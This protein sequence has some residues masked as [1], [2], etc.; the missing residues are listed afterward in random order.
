[1]MK[2]LSLQTKARPSKQVKKKTADGLK[3]KEPESDGDPQRNPSGPFTF[4][5]FEVLGELA[6]ERIAIWSRINRKIYRVAIKG[7]SLDKLDR[8]GGAEV[9]G[10][11]CRRDD[12][13]K[14]PFRFLKRQIIV[15]AGKTQLGDPDYL[16]QGIHLLSNSRLLIVNGGEARIWNGNEFAAQ[17]SPLINKKFIDFKPGASWIDMDRVVSFVEELDEAL[18]RQ[19]VVDEFLEAVS[20]WGFK[21]QLDHI[22]VAGWFLSQVVQTIWA[23]KPH[24][25]VSG[26]HGSG[27]SLLAEFF[28]KIGG[29]LA[30]KYEGQGS[31][32]AG[33]RQDLIKNDSILISIDEFEQSPQRLQILDLCRSASRGGT[34]SKGSSTHVSIKFFIYHMLLL[35]SIEIGLYRAAEN[36]RF[37]IVETRK[38]NRL[39]PQIPE[40]EILEKLRVKIFAYSIWA[41][42]KA[43][44]LVSQVK[45]IPGVDRR[46]LESMA[47]PI[48]MIAVSD[49]NPIEKLNALV[50]NYLNDWGAEQADRLQEDESKLLEDIMTANIR[51]ALT[52]VDSTGDERTIYGNRT[53]SQLIVSSRSIPE[54]GTTL[55]THGLR[56]RRDGIFMHAIK[57]RRLLL[58]NTDW[59][60]LSLREILLRVPGAI[61]MRD[62]VADSQVR[63]VLIPTAAL[64]DFLEPECHMAQSVP[65]EDH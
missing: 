16:G 64:E 27:K 6:D 17:K 62:R 36:N 1:M 32:E 39:K 46:W 28:E 13:E 14:I 38:D 5:S 29:A 4:K 9:T 43:K 45:Q 47:V 61:S 20:Q 63:G 7:L 51:L 26:K 33:I 35:C 42:L 12:G 30:R 21:S 2:V 8:I 34:I 18:T 31:S 49:Q 40:D 23:W 59:R 55:E 19:N 48:S 10:R 44:S 24:L 52:Q 53:V 15:Q 65:W 56:V 54:H 37:I 60:D 3:A 41:A 57:V 58:Q 50:S 22:M 25:W 11:V